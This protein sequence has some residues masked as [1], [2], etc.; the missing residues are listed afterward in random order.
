[1]LLVLCN[2]YYTATLIRYKSDSYRHLVGLA[3]FAKK[4]FKTAFRSRCH[5]KKMYFCEVIAIREIVWQ[6][7]VIIV[8]YANWRFTSRLLWF[9]SQK[10]FRPRAFGPM[11]ITI[12]WRPRMSPFRTAAQT[13]RRSCQ[14]ALTPRPVSGMWNKGCRFSTFGLYPVVPFRHT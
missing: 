2:K 5:Y 4:L 14:P 12:W 13:R 10:F 8:T 1:M 3:I 11:S 9:G 7:S 6:E